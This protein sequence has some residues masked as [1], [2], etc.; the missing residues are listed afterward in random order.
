MGLRFLLEMGLPPFS[1]FS[2]FETPFG[3]FGVN[4]FYEGEI[5]PGGPSLNRRGPQLAKEAPLF[6]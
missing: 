5:F 6:F 3:N 4:P 1:L 2:C